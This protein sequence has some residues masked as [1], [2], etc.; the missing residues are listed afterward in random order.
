MDCK[1]STKMEMSGLMSTLHETPSLFGL[2]IPSWVIMAGDN[3]RFSIQLSSLPK[4]DYTIEA[5]KELVDEEHPL[6][7]KLYEGVGY[8]KYVMSE[9]GNRAGTGVFKTYCGV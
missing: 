5:P 6:L 4:V 9:A 2:G 7:F 1:F 8:F 3:E